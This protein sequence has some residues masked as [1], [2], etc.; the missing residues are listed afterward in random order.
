VTPEVAQS[1]VGGEQRAAERER[2]E[3]PAALCHGQ[4]QRIVH[5]LT[6]AQVKNEEVPQRLA[7]RVVRCRQAAGDG[8]EC[9]L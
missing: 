8:G 5:M 6:T 9:R 2:G 4:E 3:T 7:G 1:V